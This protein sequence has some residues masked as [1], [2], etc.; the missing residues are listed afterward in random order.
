MSAQF[1]CFPVI[2]FERIIDTIKLISL[3]EK[4]KNL[5]PRAF[6]RKRKE[7]KLQYLWYH[8][9]RSYMKIPP[10]FDTKIRRGCILL[11]FRG[12]GVQN[13]RFLTRWGANVLFEPFH[14]S[15]L[16]GSRGGLYF[17]S[18]SSLHKSSF[19]SLMIPRECIALNIMTAFI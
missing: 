4:P 1:R 18:I 19:F 14:T 3:A 2:V 5:V 15:S 6:L 7:R 17:F 16:Y 11:D 10:N 13:A 12:L 8:N 9:F